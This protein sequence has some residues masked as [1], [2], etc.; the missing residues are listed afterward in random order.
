MNQNYGKDLA[1]GKTDREMGKNPDIWA[2]QQQ[3]VTQTY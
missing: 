3:T 2:D 1:G